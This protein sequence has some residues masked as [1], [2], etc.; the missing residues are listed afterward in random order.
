MKCNV[1]ADKID[2]EVEYT[3]N[4][5][6]GFCI[7]INDDDIEINSASID[8]Q[9]IMDVLS[10]HCLDAIEEAVWEYHKKDRD[11]DEDEDE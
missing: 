11:W 8:G 7:S 6:A 10:G 3:V 9:D 2:F 5:G 4:G 1:T